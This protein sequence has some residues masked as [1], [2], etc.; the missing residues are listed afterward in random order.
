MATASGANGTKPRQLS[1]GVVQAKGGAAPIVIGYRRIT[2]RPIYQRIRSFIGF[3]KIVLNLA[4]K[5]LDFVEE[6]AFE[7][8]NVVVEPGEEAVVY[9]A[10]EV[11]EPWGVNAVSELQARR[12]PDKPGCG[13]YAE[14]IRI[15]DK[16]AETQEAQRQ[17]ESTRPSAAPLS[18]AVMAAVQQH[19]PAQAAIR[20]RMRE[21]LRQDGHF[22]PQVP[23]DPPTPPTS[24]L[25]PS[26]PA[27]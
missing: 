27:R 6:I 15:V 8:E 9:W 1:Q 16:S 21:R 2:K 7:S 25:P 3:R 19:K 14:V 10:I 5:A 18:P 22:D 23:Q 13:Y 20:E 4:I 11:D 24:I 17:A 12:V 26:P